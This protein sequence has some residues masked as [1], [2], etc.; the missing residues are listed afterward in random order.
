MGLAL[1]TSAVRQTIRWCVLLAFVCLALLYLNSAAYSAW[2]SGG[3]PNPYPIGWSRRA[4]G[5]L[6]FSAAALFLGVGLF[7]GILTFPK[8]GRGAV[9]LLAIGLFLIAAPYIGRFVLTDRCLDQGG[10]WSNQTIQCS[11]E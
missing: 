6:F 9:V 7:R 4:L 10:S 2:V 8:V 5:H 1:K 3:P 11:N